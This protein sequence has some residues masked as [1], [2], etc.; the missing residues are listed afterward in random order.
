MEFK[1]KVIIITGAGSGIGA[2]CAELFASKGATVIVSDIDIDRAT[3]VAK[4]CNKY[5]Q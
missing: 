3:L 5:S 1:N 2:S 4:K